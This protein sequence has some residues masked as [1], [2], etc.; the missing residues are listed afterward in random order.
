MSGY[1]S[2]EYETVSPFLDSMADILRDLC[3]KAVLRALLRVIGTPMVAGRAV[4][5]HGCI[6]QAAQH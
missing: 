1:S 4:E 5:G 6:L 2:A 3:I